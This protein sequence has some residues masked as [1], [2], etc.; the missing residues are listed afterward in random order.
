[1]SWRDHIKV[2]PAADL[3]P[4]MDEAELR[5]LGADIKA[6][7]QRTPIVFYGTELLDGRNRLAAMELAGLLSIDPQSL[8]CSKHGVPEQVRHFAEDEVD[9]YSFVISAN[10]HRRHLSAEDKTKV[11]ADL[12]SAKA[13]WSDRAIAK[14]ARV[15]PTT[16]GKARA[17][18]NVQSGHKTERV[19]ASGRKARGQKPGE[20]RV[21]PEGSPST[22]PTAKIEAPP[23]IAESQSKLKLAI[24][25]LVGLPPGAVDPV[26][27][28]MELIKALP[29][30]HLERFTLDL[31][32]YLV[33]QVRE[34]I[35]A[36]GRARS[37]Q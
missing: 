14:A 1:M 13:E 23:S 18:A 6:H 22:E 26:E 2:H 27:T 31:F 33:K 29:D 34:G 16:V 19:E 20:G 24:N 30:G 12:L 35:D 5:A 11:V 3:F 4:M 37:I 15:S 10:I 32:P 9:P 36:M 8:V 25:E 7:G 17:K 28:I 21:I